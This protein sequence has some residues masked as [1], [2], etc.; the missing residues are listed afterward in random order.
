MLRGKRS[1]SYYE[2]TASQLVPVCVASQKRKGRKG[3]KS[4]SVEIVYE[5]RCIDL[6]VYEGLLSGTSG[7]IAFS[8]KGSRKRSG[9]SLT[10]E[11]FTCGCC[12]EEL[13]DD[14]P[15]FCLGPPICHDN[16]AP[17][18]PNE[19]RARKKSHSMGA[20]GKGSRDNEDYV[21]ICV[22]GVTRCVYQYDE[23]FLDNTG[24]ACGPC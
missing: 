24:Y 20:K 14:L 19:R 1:K 6:M 2:T 7:E 5:T 22:N 18:T 23:N 3:K 16:P 21:T 4:D 12:S 9:S 8:R 10:L 11:D 13:E 15:E 17:C